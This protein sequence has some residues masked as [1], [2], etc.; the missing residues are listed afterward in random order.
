MPMANMNKESA[1]KTEE[2]TNRDEAKYSGN[3]G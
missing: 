2:E 1:N 3:Y